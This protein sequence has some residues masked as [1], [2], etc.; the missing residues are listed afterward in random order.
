MDKQSMAG[1]WAAPHGTAW[2]WVL[3][4]QCQNTPGPFWFLLPGLLSAGHTL[5]WVS[6]PA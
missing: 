1:C 3:T 4:S 5:S 6:I 2:L